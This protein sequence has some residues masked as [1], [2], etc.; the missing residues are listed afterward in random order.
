M[1]NSVNIH[2]L[3]KLILSSHHSLNH[4]IMGI[5]GAT[6]L[7]HVPPGNKGLIR[8]KGT[9]IHGR[10]GIGGVGPLITNMFRYLKWLC[11]QYGYGLWIQESPPPKTA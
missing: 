6:P 3:S 2:H 11:K 8:G 4:L 1:N 7:C 9:I 10:G 5:S